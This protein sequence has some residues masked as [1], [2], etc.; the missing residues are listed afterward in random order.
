MCSVGGVKYGSRK[1]D[2]FCDRKLLDDLNAKAP[3]ANAIREFLTLLAIC[4]TVVPEKITD[5][6]GGHMIY[7]S[8]SPDETALVKGARDLKFVFHT[9]TPLCVYIEADNVIFPR[10]VPNV[11]QEITTSTTNHL[12][13]FANLGFR[14]L[15]MAVRV[16]S[17]EEYETWEPGYYQASVAIEGREKLIEAEAEKMEKVSSRTSNDL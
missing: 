13:D 5:A 16:I 11:D 9:R 6:N 14:T 3:N 7:H 12:I 17:E 2:T 4:H 8:P 15:C 1:S 10:L